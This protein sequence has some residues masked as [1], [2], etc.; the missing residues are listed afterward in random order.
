MT[1]QDQLDSINIPGTSVILRPN[2]STYNLCGRNGYCRDNLNDEWTCQC[3]FWWNGTLCNHMSNSGWQVISLSILLFLLILVFYGLIIFRAINQKCKQQ[4]NASDQHRQTTVT[5]K[6]KFSPIPRAVKDTSRRILSWIIAIA[7]LLLAVS[8]LIVKWTIIKPIHEDIVDKFK[9]NEPVF[10]KQH[11]FC[12]IMELRTEFNIVTFPLACF[13]ILIFTI[14]TRRVS[15]HGIKYSRGFIGIPIPLDFFAHVKRTL[16]AVIFAIF[17]DELLGIANDVLNANNPSTSKGVIMIYLLQLL[18]VFVIGFRCYPTLAAVYIDN[19]FSLLCATLYI[20]LDF[21]ITIFNN[22]LCKHD[23]Y[24]SEIDFNKSGA[25]STIKYLTY[26][27]AGSKLLLIQLLTDIPRYLCLAYISVKLP[28]LLFKRIRHRHTNDRTLTREQRTL[29]YS[30]LLH[31]VEAQYVKRLLGMNNTNVPTSRFS[32]IIR[33]IYEWRDDFRFS[34]RVVCVYTA[35]FLLIFFLTTQLCVRLTPTINQVQEICQRLVDFMSAVTS[36]SDDDL[37]NNEN[38]PSDFPLPNFVRPFLVAF[39]TAAC[40]IIIQ[41]LVMLAGIRRNL[42]QAYRGDDSEIP[43]RVSSANVNYVTGTFHFAGYLIGYVIVGY[44]FLAVFLFI[45][46]MS[47]DAFITYGSVKFLESILRIIVPTSLLVIF[48]IYLNKFLSKYIFLQYHGDVL[49]IN[50]RR[51]FMVFI[52]FN[53]FLDA[54]LGFIASILRI[55]RSI[56]GGII[57]MCRLDYSPLGRKLESIDAGFSAYC[58]FIYVECAHRHPVLLYFVSHLLR[59]HLYPATTQRLSKAKHK[60]H[61][62]IFLSNNPTLIYR[63]KRFLIRLQESELKIM[64]IGRK[65]MNGAYIEQPPISAHRASLIS[66]KDLEDLWTR[67]KF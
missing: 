64:L 36:A 14:I 15:T 22:G 39:I 40:I 62:A 7:T 53:F 26:Y 50:N 47:I 31:S 13:I 21:S 52:Y 25:N 9:K 67:N 45:I 38:Q 60:W 18:K 4:K 2:C 5:I 51:V 55:L 20:W 16:V 59:G 33:F 17:A 63:R 8:T 35:A 57:Y 42:L 54:F 11:Y 10:F 29:L 23:Y 32:Q 24:Q 28:A 3:K 61:L 19:W 1:A 58:G 37:E 12:R 41:L 66:A 43:R 48:K 49:S 65:H 6:R 56:V 46:I 30:S 27:G 34:S 44:I